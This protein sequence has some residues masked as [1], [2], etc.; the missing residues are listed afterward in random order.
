VTS[1]I[2][3]H[4]TADGTRRFA[5]RQ[6]ADAGRSEAS[7]RSLDGLTVSTIGVGTYLG[8]PDD[9]TDVLY[10]EAIV[11]AIGLGINHIDSAINYR[12]QRSER[13]IG[14]ALRRVFAAGV[15]DRSEIVIATKGGYVPYD[16]EAPSGPG[17]AR[18]YVSREFLSPGVCKAADFANQYRHC[19]APGYLSHQ[20]DRSRENL[21]VET[22][23]VYYLHNVE[24]QI[25]EVGRE[26]FEHRLHDAFALLESKVEEGKIGRY[27][28]ATWNGFRS[29]PGSKD[30]LPLERILRIA[31]DAGGD[32]H[33]FK[34]IQLPYNLAMTE[35]FGFF[36]Q[37]VGEKVSTALEAAARLGISVVASASLL[38]SR[39]AQDLPPEV[40]AAFE[41]GTDA[42]R[43]LQFVRSTPGVATALVGMSHTRHV[44][45]NAAL[46]A[47]PLAPE[48]AVF[49]LFDEE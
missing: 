5:D 17:A 4:A 46:L 39:L 32:G 40:T 7:F 21:G 16:G 35:A 19:M 45:E 41:V 2:A 15:V 13:A 18:E 9:V 24:G 29:E 33:H 22:L 23:D 36:N 1:P 12:F 11:E 44:R 20:I 48:S 37:P 10:T 38:Q 8:D 34:V 27:G 14:E 49:S 6:V 43:A 28:L 42:Q 47:E 25:A 26:T 31:R 3:G 30:F